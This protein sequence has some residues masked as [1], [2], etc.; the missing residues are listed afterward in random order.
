MFHTLC[1]ALTALPA[2]ALVTMLAA[3]SPAHAAAR[4]LL[5]MDGAGQTHS[6][7][8]YRGKPVVVHIWATWC[9]P[10][11]AEMPELSAWLHEHPDVPFLPISVDESASAAKNFLLQ[12][13]IA[14][15]LLL[16]DQKQASSLGVRVLPSTFVISGS[17]KVTRRLFGSQAW[18]DK[19]FS[20]SLLDDVG[21]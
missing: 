12:H 13:G 19:D 9:P 16:T 8:E 15:P 2:V 7:A 21:L 18:A 14:L 4:S 20:Q 10:C 6:L 1:R 11:R 3:P 17:G 5:W